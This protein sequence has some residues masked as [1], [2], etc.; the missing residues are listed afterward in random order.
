MS[1][2][3]IETRKDE[4][5]LTTI[6]PQEMIG[7]FLAERLLRS[8]KE[9]FVDEDTAE[10]VSIE[11]SE[12][13]L[14]KGT[15]IDGQ[16]LAEIS[17][18]IQSGDIK[19]VVVSNQRRLAYSLKNESFYPFIAVI[20]M[21]NKNKKFILHAASVEMA[22][23]IV[24]D[25]VELTFSEGF[26]L[27]QIKEFERCIILKDTLKKYE[28]DTTIDIEN[29]DLDEF[30]DEPLELKFYSINVTIKNEETEYIQT[31]L[32]ET[33]DADKAMIVIKDYITRNYTENN[34][35]TEYLEIKLETAKIVP[36]D[37]IIEKE[38]SMAYSE[39][40]QQ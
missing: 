34:T 15:K 36:C 40:K 21:R 9:D 3:K 31:F 39:V 27:T 37:S 11:R 22:T 2:I 10:V 28:A 8:W 29:I 4:I 19:E 35:S 18:F 14:D 33:T 24:K 20:R 23:E 26:I 25:Y 13:I 17:F 12:I 30:Q 32:V 16:N 1:K 7:K 5:H 6:D 38:F